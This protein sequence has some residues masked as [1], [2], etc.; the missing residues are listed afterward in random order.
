VQSA[1][2]KIKDNAKSKSLHTDLTGTSDFSSFVKPRLAIG[3][4]GNH[5]PDAGDVVVGAMAQ[6]VEMTNDEVAAWNATRGYGKSSGRSS[7][8]ELP[9]AD[10][11]FAKSVKLAAKQSV[12][13]EIPVTAA[14][15]FG[16]TFMAPADISA[17][18][19]NEAGAIVGKNLT[20]T[21]EATQWFRSIFIDK[22]TT[23]ATWKMRLENT[24]D[25]EAEV[26]LTTWMNPAR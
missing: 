2:W 25:R 20:K 18:L 21:P 19:L 14:A 8:M 7:A 12:D 17:T 9:A 10:A 26:I 11:P 15:S 16:I 24:S 5:N 13:V 6:V 23:L 3:P 1:I 22:P 4:K